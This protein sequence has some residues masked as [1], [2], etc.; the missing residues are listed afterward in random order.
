MCHAITNDNLAREEE[1]VQRV[2]HA[3][4]AVVERRE[5]Q[6]S[7]SRLHRVGA[8]SRDERAVEPRRALG[9][10]VGR[11]EPADLLLRAQPHL[12]LERREPLLLG[13]PRARRRRRG[14]GVRDRGR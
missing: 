14:G 8:A 3:L 12:A 2:E 6:L 13:A 1:V 5:G 11:R 9:G 10:L 4:A 7:R